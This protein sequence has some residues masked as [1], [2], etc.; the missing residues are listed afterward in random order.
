M[1]T[2]KCLLQLGVFGPYIKHKSLFYSLAKTDDPTIITKERAIE[3]I[4]ENV[5]N[6]GK[7]YQRI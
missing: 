1:K 7:P 2:K 5:K 6:Q 4:E 3:I